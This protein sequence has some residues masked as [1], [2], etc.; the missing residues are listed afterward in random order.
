MN[1]NWEDVIQKLVEDYKKLTLEY[2]DSF[3]AEVVGIFKSKKQNYEITITINET[4]SE[5]KHTK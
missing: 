5:T 1:I 3:T 4:S 2:Q